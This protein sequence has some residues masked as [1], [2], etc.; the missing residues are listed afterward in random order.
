MSNKIR[1]WYAWLKHTDKQTDITPL[2]PAC[3][4]SGTRVT[5]AARMRDNPL[6]LDDMS[7]ADG[8]YG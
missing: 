5:T 7:A 4:P 6:T 2:Q 8:N 3:Q 1:E